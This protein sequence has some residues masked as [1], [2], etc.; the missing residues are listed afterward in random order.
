MFTGVLGGIC[1]V[2]QLAAKGCPEV[3]VKTGR[4][5]AGAVREYGAWSK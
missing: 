4:E 1:F 3:L 5:T 2:F